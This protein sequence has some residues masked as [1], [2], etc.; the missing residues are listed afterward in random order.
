[1]RKKYTFVRTVQMEKM[2]MKEKKPAE[3][4]F[5]I[6]V[7]DDFIERRRKRSLTYKLLSERGSKV[8]NDWNK[9]LISYTMGQCF[10]LQS[11]IQFFL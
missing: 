3:K 4:Q 9:V 7:G 10:L 11:V 1:M 8:S 6:A 2:K 5:P